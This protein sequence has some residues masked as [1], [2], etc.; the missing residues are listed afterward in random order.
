MAKTVSAYLPQNYEVT[1]ED[2]QYVYF[3][4]E[5]KAGWTMEDY[6]IPRLASGLM[7]AKETTDETA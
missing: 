5:D 3:E 1:R 7:F 6:V 4:G 2:E